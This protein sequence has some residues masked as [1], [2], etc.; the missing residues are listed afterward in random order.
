MACLADRIARACVHHYDRC[1]TKKGKPR[2]GV[3]WT[4]MAAVVG[5]YQDNSRDDL[6]VI[7]MGTGSKCVGQNQMSGRG[8]LLHDS[9]AEVLARRGFVRFLLTEVRRLLTG[10]D[11]SVLCADHERSAEASGEFACRVK[12]GVSFHFFTTQT[13]CGDA[14]IYKLPGCLLLPTSGADSE[15]NAAGPAAAASTTTKSTPAPAISAG[16]VATSSSGS[17]VSARAVES[18]GVTRRDCN[19]ANPPRRTAD[20]D[21]RRTG[22]HLSSRSAPC[23]ASSADVCTS[24][25]VATKRKRS[26]VTEADGALGSDERD[27][28]TRSA[29]HSHESAHKRTRPHHME[30]DGFHE[31][32]RPSSPSRDCCCSSSTLSPDRSVGV[33]SSHATSRSGD[34]GS[35]AELVQL[36]Q[37]TFGPGG[38]RCVC[39]PPDGL[40]AR[41]GSRV[42]SPCTTSRSGGSNGCA[43]STMN[44]PAL[45]ATASSTITASASAGVVQCVVAGAQSVSNGS[46]PDLS[47]SESVQSV[48]DRSSPHLPAPSVPDGVQPVSAGIQSVVSTASTGVQCVSDGSSTHL[49]TNAMAEVLQCTGVSNGPVN[50]CC[51]ELAECSSQSSNILD[52]PNGSAAV[53]TSEPH[54]CTDETRAASASAAPAATDIRRTGAKCAPASA[55]Q[56]ARRPGSEYHT[57][58]AWRTKPGRG[59]PTISMSCSDKLARWNA[60]GCQGALA[61]HFLAAPVRF[62]SIT[63]LAGHERSGGGGGEDAV[64]LNALRRAVTLR[65]SRTR[66]SSCDDDRHAVELLSTR[67]VAFPARK[68]YAGANAAAA[69]ACDGLVN[70]QDCGKMND[71]CEDGHTT[72]TAADGGDRRVACGSSIAWYQHST[73]QEA[74]CNGKKLGITKKLRNSPKSRSFLCRVDMFSLFMEILAL[75]PK[76]QLPSHL[77]NQS[78]QTYLDFKL[79]SRSYQQRKQE[80]LEHVGCWVQASCDLQK[81]SNPTGDSEV[82]TT[83]PF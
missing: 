64:D 4:P 54:Q 59:D 52:G 35:D 50:A 1:L 65:L 41:T 60:I 17:A 81:F 68:S 9:H 53:C 14:S 73:Q 57:A 27:L 72:T 18:H 36:S 39:G 7:S 20:L 44:C 42:L 45:A 75:V 66:E 28:C 40:H 37:K 43:E 74:T 79:A 11:T 69:A 82:A 49:P 30:G 70:G 23:P 46:S 80:F 47:V 83:R 25:G 5:R 6:F 2:D 12:P 48:S 10:D 19:G 62:A 13:P 63:V 22:D 76:D 15:R 67:C 77:R 58:G 26:D 8:D 61:A 34:Y 56:D 38:S 29:A 16:D 51:Q 32:H 21:C 31:Q 55:L 33:S 78:L 71:G 3:E 24:P